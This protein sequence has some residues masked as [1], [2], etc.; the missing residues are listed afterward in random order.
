M[1]N[2]R[3]VTKNAERLV[4]GQRFKGLSANQMNSMLPMSQAALT[5]MSDSLKAKSS[6]IKKKI[7]RIKSKVAEPTDGNEGDA[8]DIFIDEEL[9]M[10]APPLTQL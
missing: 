7:L 10:T 6:G 8:E 1:E 3:N 5:S 9:Q 4:T 2:E